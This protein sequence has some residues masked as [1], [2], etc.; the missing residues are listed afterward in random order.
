MNVSVIAPLNVISTLQVVF[1]GAGL[2]KA[3]ERGIYY[4]AHITPWFQLTTDLQVIEP[5]NASNDE[6]V[7][8]GLRGKIVFENPPISHQLQS[9]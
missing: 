5:A 2:L 8:F 9:G 7:V 1:N 4:N 6:A 3:G